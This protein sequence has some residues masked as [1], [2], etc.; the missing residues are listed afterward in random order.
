MS[1]QHRNRRLLAVGG[2]LA[3]VLSA[4]FG[5]Q[6]A[7]SA[8]GFPEVPDQPGTLTIHKHVQAENSTPGNPAGAPLGDVGFRVQQ[9]GV[10]D[11]ATCVT[12]DLTTPEGWAAVSDAIDGF[13]SGIPAGFCATSVTHD[14]FTVA[15]GQIAVPGLK[16]LFLVTETSPGPHLIDDPAAPFLVTVPMPVAG[17]PAS[18]NFDVHAYPKNRLTS[19]TP[20]KTVGDENVESTVVPGALVPWE[21]SAPVP[22][23]A[24][25]YSVMT[26][27]DN[28]GAGHTFAAWGAITLDGVALNGPTEATP[29]YTITGNSISLTPAGLAKLNAIVTGVDARSA[30][31][32]AELTTQVALD[33]APGA[34]VNTAS[35]TLNGQTFTTPGPQSNWGKIIVTKHV[36]GNP[37]ATLAGAKF[38]IYE[39]TAAG[40]AVDVTGT[41]VW[42]TPAT[43][44]PSAAV[45]SAVLWISNTEPG[46]AVGSKTYC[47]LETQAPA[48]HVLDST[49][50]AITV[51]SA[52]DSVSTYAFPNVPVEGPRLPLTGGSGTVAFGIAGLAMMVAAG[53]LFA[54]RKVRT[55]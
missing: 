6:T 21:V 1:Q 46:E 24:F 41:P 27:T 29:D 50:R 32:T 22:V 49:P 35:I 54:V 14:V 12:L 33:V 53:A 7:A 31:L 17:P 9:L 44:D 15:N 55:R 5:A 11:G 16:G 40:C 47:L 28:P 2:T 48:G 8:N 3:L 45:Q 30:T 25:P 39:Q 23:A 36:S 51:S 34:L 18:W 20:L 4:L 42:Q 43:P 52:N 13:T 10:M 26:I 37:Q 38:A 19:L